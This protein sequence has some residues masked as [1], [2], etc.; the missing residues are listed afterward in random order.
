MNHRFVAFDGLS[1]VAALIVV[2]G[3]LIEDGPVKSL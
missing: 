2:V 1:G 3:H